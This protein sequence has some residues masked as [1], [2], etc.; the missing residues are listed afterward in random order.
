MNGQLVVLNYIKR[1][2]AARQTGNLFLDKLGL[3]SIPVE[4]FLLT[5][6]TRL[7]L[8]DNDISELPPEIEQLENLKQLIVDKNKLK[9]LP[10]ELGKLDNLELLSVAANQI[11]FLPLSLCECSNI[12]SIV[13]SQNKLETPPPEIIQEGTEAIVQYMR[14]LMEAETYKRLDLRQMGLTFFPR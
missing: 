1:I 7:K 9:A 13:V 14:T 2:H 4:V 10:D 6:L 11:E 3:K 5:S 12:Q 8:V